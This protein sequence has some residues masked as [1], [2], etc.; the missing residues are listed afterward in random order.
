MYLKYNKICNF[1]ISRVYY[2]DIVFINFC[3]ML[4]I[5]ELYSWFLGILIKLNIFLIIS[6]NIK[7]DL[8]YQFAIFNRN[9]C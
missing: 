4:L 8:K 3:K 7:N 9:K 5:S 2:N 6:K 1:F